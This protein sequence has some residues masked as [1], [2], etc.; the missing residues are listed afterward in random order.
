MQLDE[1]RVKQSL[2]AMWR[3]GGMDSLVK[4]MPAE[5]VLDAGFPIGYCTQFKFIA[6]RTPFEM[7]RAVGFRSNTKLVS[8][9]AIYIVRPLPAPGQILLRGYSQ[10]PEGISTSVKS[11]H[12]DYPPGLGV[13]Q[14]EILASQSSL[15]SIATVAPGEMFR[16]MAARLGPIA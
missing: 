6:G 10:T 9:A 4:V 11:A 2:I 15:V 7:E 8:G 3:Q 12:P 1:M 13:P 5:R 16:F 14:W